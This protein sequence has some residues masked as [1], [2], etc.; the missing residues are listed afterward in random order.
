MQKERGLIGVLK[1]P[2]ITRSD[3]SD[4][5]PSDRGSV[6]FLLNSGT[7]SFLEG[8]EFPSSRERPK[9][10]SERLSTEDHMP[11]PKSPFAFANDK[12][13]DYSFLSFNP[14]PMEWSFFND[15]MFLQFLGAPFTESQR[16][17][18]DLYAEEFAPRIIG[19]HSVSQG[20]NIGV[21]PNSMYETESTLAA[22]MVQSILVK[23]FTLDLDKQSSEE[24]ARVLNF[25]LTP[26][27]LDRF[28]KQYFKY[29]HPHCPILHAA[30]FDSD[31]VPVPLLVSVVFM[32]AIYSPYDE[33][34]NAAKKV[35]DLAELY[36]YSTAEI[37]E[38]FEI[39]EAMKGSQ[40]SSETDNGPMAFQQLQAVYLMLVV[41][42]WAGSQVSKQRAI[43]VRFGQVIKV[44]Y[45]TTRV[46][47]HCP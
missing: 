33:E 17:L 20:A 11:N 36:V 1:A 9:R 6:N 14:D 2:T 10:N 42:Y 29:W 21:N 13:V 31:S 22:E 32:G 46:L 28:V 43:E 41:Q 45:L 35:L 38:E 47:S 34:V 7:Q 39:R 24:A 44:S 12:E 18:D 37:S 25:L 15:D 27:R 3:D 30:T 23:S 19:S 40:K 26:N 4:N 8:F 16:P 5:Q